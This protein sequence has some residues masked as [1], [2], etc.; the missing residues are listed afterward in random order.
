MPSLKIVQFLFLCVV[1]L[2]SVSAVHR[3]LEEAKEAR[4]N[5]VKKYFKK[6]KKQEGA[7]KLVGGSGDNEGD[8]N[9]Y[10]FYFF[11]NPKCG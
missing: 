9:T 6:L 10:I 8:G 7:I 11:L 3:T 2:E 5:L 1:C 4:A